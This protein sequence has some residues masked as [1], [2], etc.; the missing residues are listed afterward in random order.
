MGRCLRHL[1]DNKN[2]KSESTPTQ[3]DYP[4]AG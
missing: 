1:G 4:I 2:G 3:Q